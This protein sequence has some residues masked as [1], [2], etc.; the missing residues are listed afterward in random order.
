MERNKLELKGKDLL[1][2]ALIHG[3]CQDGESKFTGSISYISNWLGISKSTVQEILSKLVKTGR[4]IKYE[5]LK[6]P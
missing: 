4:L 6:I 3:F 1:V 2:Y 5:I